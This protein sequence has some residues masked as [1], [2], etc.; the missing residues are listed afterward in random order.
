MMVI[1]TSQ[2]VS[3]LMDEP[4]RRKVISWRDECT[5]HVWFKFAAILLHF[6]YCFPVKSMVDCCANELLMTSVAYEYRQ[7]EITNI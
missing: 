6:H 4:C 2:I 5:T 3:I 1:N 7:M